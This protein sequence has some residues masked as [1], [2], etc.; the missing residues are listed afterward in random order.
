MTSNSK[1]SIYISSKPKADTSFLK[2]LLNNP[3]FWIG[4]VY[5]LSPIDLLPGPI[6]DVLID[7]LLGIIGGVYALIKYIK[8][9]QL[10][11]KTN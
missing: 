4:A 1:P 8:D 9:K 5:S 7:I 3:L 2:N 11:S 10:E 6:D